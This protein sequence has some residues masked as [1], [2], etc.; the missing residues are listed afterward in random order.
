MSAA[1]V[2]GLVAFGVLAGAAAGMLGIGGGTLMV[3]F[4]T[5][6]AEL[7]QHSAEASSLLVILP[8]AIVSVALLRRRGFGDLRPAM[9]TGAIGA[10]G[11]FV[12]VRLALAL[13]ADTLQLLFACFLGAIGV[14]MCRDAVAAPRASS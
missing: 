12:G 1:L 5:L 11:G 7:T 4:L 10:I 3:P 13:P 14:R 9:L 8:A 2:I 6:V